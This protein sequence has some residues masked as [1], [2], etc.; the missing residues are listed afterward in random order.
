M[1][2]E[3]NALPLAQYTVTKCE[4]EENL[5]ATFNFKRSCTSS[6]PFIAEVL[7]E[8]F[9]FQKNSKHGL[10]ASSSRCV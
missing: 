10:W 6:S 1:S 3:C 2:Y 7:M 4:A 9:Y 5:S 8:N